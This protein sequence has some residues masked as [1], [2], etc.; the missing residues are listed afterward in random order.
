MQ[1]ELLNKFM[2]DLTKRHERLLR[3]KL[4]DNANKIQR[5]EYARFRRLIQKLGTSYIIAPDGYL[6]IAPIVTFC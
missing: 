2:T 3:K 1:M 4:S 5:A 6:D